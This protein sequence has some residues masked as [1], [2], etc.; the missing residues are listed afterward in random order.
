[1]AHCLPTLTGA[2]RARLAVELEH[3]GERGTTHSHDYC[4]YLHSLLI[5]IGL[6]SHTNDIIAAPVEI[7]SK[8]HWALRNPVPPARV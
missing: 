4:D 3:S 1:M 8:R 7:D 5:R 2:M 6:G